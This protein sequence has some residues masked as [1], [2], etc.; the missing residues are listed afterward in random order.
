[1]FTWFIDIT[2]GL[3]SFG[4]MYLNADLVQKNLRSLSDKWDPKVATIQ[5]AKDLNT[6]SLDELMGSLITYELTMQHRTEDEQ[7]KKKSIALKAV[8]EK[9][10][11]SEDE[12]SSDNGIQDE[13]FEISNTLR[14]EGESVTT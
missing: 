8:I 10:E 7:K 5:E 12:H 4:Q 9:V 13:D 3:K 1:M 2:N 11:E 6:L 14:G